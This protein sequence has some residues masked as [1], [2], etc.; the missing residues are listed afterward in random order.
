MKDR[1][2]ETSIEVY[3]VAWQLNTG[4]GFDWYLDQEGCTK[5]FEQEL[6]NCDRFVD[7][8]WRA[9]TAPLE[10]NSLGTATDEIEVAL[11]QEGLFE[12]LLMS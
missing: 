1:K 6:L 10:V 5:A 12:S 3:K 9:V 2:L 11:W 8:E 7:V 4:G